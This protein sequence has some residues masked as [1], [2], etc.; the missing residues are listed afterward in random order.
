MYAPFRSQR[1]DRCDGLRLSP[2][3]SGVFDAP[4]HPARIRSLGQARPTAPTPLDSPAHGAPPV[5]HPVDKLAQCRDRACGLVTFGCAGHLGSGF[6]REYADDGVG[7]W[8]G[9]VGVCG[10]VRA[11]VAVLLAVLG[12]CMKVLVTGS[13]GF[14]CSSLVSG[15][16][17]HGTKD[18]ECVI[19]A[20]RQEWVQDRESG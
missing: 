2:A 9:G 10:Y 16:L 6:F 20:A 7:F 4:A 17:A 18:P 14:I 15:L 5:P 13:A 19:K 12:G 3:G 1:L 11:S 8:V